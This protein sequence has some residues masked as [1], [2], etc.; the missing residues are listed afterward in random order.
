VL[1]Y[2][3]QLSPDDAAQLYATC[4]IEH[5]LTRPTDQLSGGERQRVAIARLLSTNPQWLL[6]DEPFSHLDFLHKSL[7]K[8]VLT[9]ASAARGVSILLVSHE[10]SDTLSWADEMMAMRAGHVLQQGAPAALY[11]QPVDGYVAGL[12]GS[13]TELSDREKKQLGWQ[14]NASRFFRPEHF[15]LSDEGVAG[16]VVRLLFFGA[17]VDALVDIGSRTVP[18]RTTPGRVVPGQRVYVRAAIA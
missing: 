6:L 14:R 17:H 7:L 10:P 5:L 4:H 11:Q 12:L 18:V 13:F 3:N 16:T 9:E 1:A 15:V 2:A 8:Q